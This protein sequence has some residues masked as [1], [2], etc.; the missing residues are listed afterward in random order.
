MGAPPFVGWL[1]DPRERAQLLRRFPPSYPDILADHVTLAF[2]AAARDIACPRTRG[3]EI[4]G[5]VDDGA[6]VEALVVRIG[7]TTTR[8]GGGTYH[9]TWSIDRARG[10]KPVDSNDVMAGR[11]FELLDVPIAIRLIPTDR[12]HRARTDAASV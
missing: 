6:G 4:V 9:I 2:G 10:R 12:L 7:G 3:G 5:H 8:P 1:L 11:A